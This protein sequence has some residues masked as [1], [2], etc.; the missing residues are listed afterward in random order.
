MIKIMPKV[1]VLLELFAGGEELSVKEVIRRSGLNQSNVSHLLKSLCEENMLEHTG[2]GKYRRAERLVRLC[3]GGNPWQELLSKAERCAD[4]LISWLNELA[5]VGM[6]DCDRRLTIVKRRPLKSLQVDMGPARTYPAN[7]YET[8]SGRVLLAYAPGE[9]V[10]K[11]VARCGLPERKVW[12]EACSLPKLAA[13]LARIREQGFVSMDVDELIRALGV[14]VRDA[15]G[16]ILLSLST[17]YPV[18][19]C[20]R[21]EEE[22]IRYMR[23]LV[24]TLEEELRIGGM[25]IIELKKKTF[26]T[27]CNK[28]KTGERKP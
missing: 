27:D 6:R 9:T 23:E 2:Y 4:N 28:I 26:E 10:R 12:R 14:P 20:R 17:A 24:S 1:I 22:I 18:F 5:V 7:W 25:R 16:E 13:E 19:S 21:K 15:S 3:T 11:I 8:A